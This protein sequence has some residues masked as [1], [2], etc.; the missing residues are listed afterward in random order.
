M[1][2]AR[3][4]Q[5]LNYPL[6]LLPAQVLACQQINDVHP[7]LASTLGIDAQ[8]EGSIALIT[9]DQDDSLYIAVDQATKFADISV[10]FG[11]S[12]YAGSKHSSGPFSGEVLCILAGKTPDDVGEGVWAVQQALKE[13]I[14]FATFADKKLADSRKPAFIS[15]V[16]PEIGSY[17]AEQAGLAVG[18]SMAYLIAPPLESIYAIDAALKAAPVKLQKMLPPPS[19]TNFGG[20]YLSGKQADLEASAAAFIDAIA[21]ISQFPTQSMRRPTQ[22]RR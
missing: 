22:M 5:L 4:Q 14:C 9:A 8:Q 6:E 10:R 1:T 2:W 20:A 13:P 15:Y 17:L 7:A 16:I 3:L 11:R 21:Q 18:D 12:F 19:E